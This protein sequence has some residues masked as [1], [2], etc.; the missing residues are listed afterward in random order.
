MDFNWIYKHVQLTGNVD[1]RYFI[2]TDDG[3]KYSP[4]LLR[5]IADDAVNWFKERIIA[6]DTDRIYST[7]KT[8]LVEDEEA[9]KEAMAPYKNKYEK[10]NQKWEE[11]KNSHENEF[12][13]EWR[14][15]GSS[16][17]DMHKITVGFNPI[18]AMS[19]K[20]AVAGYKAAKEM[21][22]KY[23]S[24]GDEYD[25]LPKYVSLVSSEDYVNQHNEMRKKW[26]EELGLPEKDSDL[27]VKVEADVISIKRSNAK[28]MMDV[29]PN[30][31]FLEDY[32]N[33]YV[34]YIQEQ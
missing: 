9:T 26:R 18:I 25:S 22:A 10:F 34:A 16:K 32:A 1:E 23:S 31:E 11:Y 6:L 30:E 20:D 4:V 17:A 14:V 24:G 28:I 8:T 29:E 19:V 27:K 33:Q 7:E 5:I 13:E 3:Y 21:S 15:D 12:V 2:Q